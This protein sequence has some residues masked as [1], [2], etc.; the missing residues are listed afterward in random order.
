MRLVID[1]FAEL[2]QV[3]A[4][5][6]AD[7]S[8]DGFARVHQDSSGGWT[9][10]P[11]P[12]GSQSVSTDADRSISIQARSVLSVHCAITALLRG[13]LKERRA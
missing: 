3:A 7:R 9:W 4:D 1:D 8:A 10:T 6:V 11:H 2:H 5:D 12:M 13:G